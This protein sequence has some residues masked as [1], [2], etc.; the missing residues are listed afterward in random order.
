MWFVIMAKR[1]RI[2]QQISRRQTFH[3]RYQ[4][5]KNLTHGF[6][7]VSWLPSQGVHPRYG[8][9]QEWA[10]IKA[11]DVLHSIQCVRDDGI[12]LADMAINFSGGKPVR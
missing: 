11:E 7:E 9:I 5:L 2:N 8:E 4:A 6:Q 3:T 10:R 12:C 1:Y